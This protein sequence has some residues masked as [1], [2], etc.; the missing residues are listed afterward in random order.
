MVLLFVQNVVV[1]FIV[2]DGNL[3][4]KLT[5]PSQV[6]N[7]IEVFS[8]RLI[9]RNNSKMSQTEKQLISKFEEILKEIRANR[10]NN[11]ATC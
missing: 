5:E 3:G 1:S 2:F 4:S 6:S 8:Q 9:E 7:E 10:N 11:S